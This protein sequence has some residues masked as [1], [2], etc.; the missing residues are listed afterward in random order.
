[1]HDNDK[2][3]T[4]I[5]L[6]PKGKGYFFITEKSVSPTL[7]EYSSLVSPAVGQ[8]GIRWPDAMQGSVHNIT[9]LLF[10]SEMFNLNL[11]MRK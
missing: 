7:T 10:L 8:S 11:I 6:L 2:T 9:S 5:L 3:H 1:M 4:L